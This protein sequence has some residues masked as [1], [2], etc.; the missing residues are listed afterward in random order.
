MLERKRKECKGCG[1]MEYIWAKGKCKKCYMLGKKSSRVFKVTDRYKEVKDSEY[2]AMRTKWRTLEMRDGGV[3]CME[4]GKDLGGEMQPGNMA[5]VLSK[6]SYPSFR[7]D[8][9]NLV[10]MCYEHHQMMDGQVDGKVRSDMGCYE[11]LMDISNKLKREYY[12][13]RGVK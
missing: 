2:S 9:R 7:C 4:C 5:H 1:G 11:E 6:G 10:A 3:Y 12:T 13:L 8:L